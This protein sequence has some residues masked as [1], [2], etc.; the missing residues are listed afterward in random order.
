MLQPRVHS[1]ERQ[2]HS[3]GPPLASAG[4]G[5]ASLG[6]LEGLIAVEGGEGSGG[7]A[8]GC[9]A[10]CGGASSLGLGVHD[11]G[12]VDVRCCAVAATPGLAVV[13]DSAGLTGVVVGSAAARGPKALSS[14]RPQ[15][16]VTVRRA[17]RGF[18]VGTGRASEFLN[19]QLI[20]CFVPQHHPLLP[21][22]QDQGA[23]CRSVLYCFSTS[24]M[25]PSSA[26]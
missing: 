26:R 14:A 9:A 1:L 13:A 10:L 19:G 3:I 15:S 7:V 12:V 4:V 8:A 6:E 18:L 5:G 20:G 23:A 22:K 2:Q 25:G 17:D 24:E 16:T 11:P 21:K